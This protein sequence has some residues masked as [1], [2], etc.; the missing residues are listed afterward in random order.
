MPATPWF[1]SS[2]PPLSQLGATI[3]RG[4]P[5]A[6]TGTPTN[7]TALPQP[8]QPPPDYTELFTNIQKQQQAEADRTYSLN[9]SKLDNEYN[10]ARRQAKTAEEALAIDREYKQAAT[11]LAR[12][13]LTED[14]R[15][16][17]MS[18]GEGQRQFDATLG[19]NQAKLGYDLIGTAAQLR[20][21]DNYFQASNFSRGVA[22]QPG[23]ATFLDAL[24]NNTSLAAFGAQAGSPDAVSLGSITGRLLGGGNAGADDSYLGSIHGI[25]AQGGHR[26]GAGRWEELSPTEQRLFLSGLE[27]PDAQGKAFD[28]PTFLDQHRK[29]RIANNYAN[30]RAA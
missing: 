20:G 10:I 24:R 16:F 14:S 28:A 15:Q 7:P 12:D 23:T 3:G 25:A 8:G 22:A 11:A 2:T 27:A 30:T 29:S 17:N 26:L 18:F 5:S 9:R 19:L 4:L 6:G 13:R 1:T 21:A